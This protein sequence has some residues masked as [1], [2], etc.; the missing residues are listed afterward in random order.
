MKISNIRH[1]AKSTE[2]EYIEPRDPPNPM[3]SAKF[4]PTKPPKGATRGTPEDPDYY[5]TPQP[6]HNWEDDP[7]YEKQK[8]I[9][10]E[11]IGKLEPLI[12]KPETYIDT[13]DTRKAFNA[14]VLKDAGEDLDKNNE[15]W[16]ERNILYDLDKMKFN[17]LKKNN[18]NI[19]H[20]DKTKGVLEW[21]RT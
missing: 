19:L 5:Y 3:Y 6:M 15:E 1:F 2:E 11:F 16:L 8:E 7:D 14:Q 10:D 13:P 9:M 21:L 18:E 17:E 20:T 4:T 12:D